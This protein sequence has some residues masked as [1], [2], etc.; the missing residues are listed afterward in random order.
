MVE[1]IHLEVLGHEQCEAN[2]ERE[3]LRA[4][5]HD[6]ALQ[7]IYAV[8]L[9]LETAKSLI[10]TAPSEAR[11]R[12]SESIQQLNHA[13]VQLRTL[14]GDHAQLTPAEGFP[15][16]LNSLI[17]FFRGISSTVFC[18]SIEPGA[19]DGLSKRQM[20][21]LQ[22]IMRGGLF[23]VIRHAR[24]ETC[25]VQLT[26]DSHQVRVQIWDDGKGF[27]ITRVKQRSNGLLSM[28]HRAKRIRA[29]FRLWSQPGNGTSLDVAIPL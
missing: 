12:V 11:Q 22:N 6:G 26:R 19:V 16:A 10:N 2:S 29:S 9:Q 4:N 13:I 27:D 8:G 21:H 1:S 20:S 25:V 7:T 23:N 3:T 18:V 17:L 15:E 28:T 24:A 14:L 5:L